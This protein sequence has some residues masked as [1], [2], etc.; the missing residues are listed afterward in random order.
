M[1]QKSLH[2]IK[3]DDDYLAPLAPC[4]GLSVSTMI[5]KPSKRG[6]RRKLKVRSII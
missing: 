4:Q 6:R 1:E 5:A 3:E 2:S